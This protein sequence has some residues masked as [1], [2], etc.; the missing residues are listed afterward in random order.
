MNWFQRLFSKKKK[1]QKAEVK[2]L[3]TSVSKHTYR[4]A[5][6]MSTPKTTSRDD[7]SASYPYYVGSDNYTPGQSSNDFSNSHASPPSHDYG[8]SS[9]WG[10]SSSHSHDSSSS[11]SSDSSSY[12]SD[13]GSSS[14]DSGG[15]SDGGGGGD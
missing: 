1:D 15:S 14:S 7:G 11:S 4:D 6:R 8:S 10:G 5:A 3:S 13:S 2:E 12:S 9:N